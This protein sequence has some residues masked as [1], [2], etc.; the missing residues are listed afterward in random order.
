M[1]SQDLATH[2]T[3]PSP[4]L[5]NVGLRIAGR[6]RFKVTALR[7]N[8]PASFA[9]V[10]KVEAELWFIPPME[11]LPVTDVGEGKEWFYEVK[12]DGYR[13][14]AIKQ[15][16]EV[17]LY[18]RNGK[19]LTKFLNFYKELLL[20]RG[21]SFILDGEIVCLNDEGRSSFE[22]LQ[23]TGR[24]HHRPVTFYVFDVLHFEGKN[25]VNVPLRVRRA[26]LDE[27]FTSLPPHVRLS[28]ILDGPLPVVKAKVREFELE[29]LVAKRWD[30]IYEP[31]KRTGAWQKHKTQRTDE[32]VIGGYIGEKSVEQ[33]VIGEERE[34]QWQF[35][36][37]VKNGFVSQTRRDVWKAIQKFVAS[38]C[39]FVNLP[40]KRR[41]HAMDEEKMKQVQWV[42]PKVIAEIAFNERTANG[43][44]RHS[45]YLRLRP[46]KSVADVKR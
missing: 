9:A 31:G 17:T 8:R 3:K 21:K 30:S 16:N 36:E 12:H 13:A 33:L 46:D 10:Q 7:T 41:P 5:T 14:I 44:L 42:K 37:A 24:S 25:F 1:A 29:G 35:V 26:F 23:R 2:R 4:I 6:L 18:S 43:H 20:V 27:T 22:L 11:C 34:G 38:S 45:R 15:K 28:A 19:L 40:E 32:F 39:P